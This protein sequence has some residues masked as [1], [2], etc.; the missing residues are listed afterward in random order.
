M[1]LNMGAAD[2]PAA[3]QL[4]LAGVG[5]DLL[6]VSSS[7]L[8]HQASSPDSL[9]IGI[10]LLIE[11]CLVSIFVI[12][13]EPVCDTNLLLK[14]IK[15]LRCTHFYLNWLISCRTRHR[16]CNHTDQHGCSSVEKVM[17]K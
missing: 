15:C 5:S 7:F 1:L 4:S 14:T 16:A 12:A 11:A 9:Y 6:D 8:E 10:L 3:Y 2:Y 13:Y 17:T